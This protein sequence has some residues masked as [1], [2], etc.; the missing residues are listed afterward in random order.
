M[1]KIR[2]ARKT[3]AKS[4]QANFRCPES[5]HLKALDYCEK[6]DISLA[7]FYRSAIRAYLKIS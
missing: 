4:V 1:K 6:E 5:L 3:E 7:K 2:K